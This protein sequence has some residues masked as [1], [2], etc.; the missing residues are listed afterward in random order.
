MAVHSSIL[1]W[2]IPWTV[3]PGGLQFMGSQ[4][5]GHNWATNTHKW[6]HVVLVFFWL[7]SLSMIISRT[8]HVATNSII[9]FFLWLSSIPLYICTTSFLWC[10]LWI[11]NVFFIVSWFSCS[12]FSS[13]V[14][15]VVDLSFVSF[16]F[17]FH[18]PISEL[19]EFS[20]A[21]LYF[22]SFIICVYYF[23]ASIVILLLTQP[24]F[25]ISTAFSRFLRY[26]S[27]IISSSYIDATPCFILSRKFLNFSPCSRFILLSLL[28]HHFLNLESFHMAKHY[29][30]FVQAYRG[31]YMLI[32]N[33]KLV[34]VL[35]DI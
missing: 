29:S 31:R 7:T 25:F 19:G 24:M 23:N 32:V 16:C 21:Y 9:S 34:W 28:C 10:L 8:I 4:R 13:T 27:M 22:W 6:Y 18:L 35:R 33:W 17:P 12:S 2:R 11:S 5:V 20:W 15:D 30:L 14:L 26:P 1:A 3:E